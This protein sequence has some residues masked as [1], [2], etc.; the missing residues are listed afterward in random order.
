MKLRLVD[1]GADAGTGK[2]GENHWRNSKS[3]MANGEI[4]Q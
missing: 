4:K 2:D 1:D 3:V